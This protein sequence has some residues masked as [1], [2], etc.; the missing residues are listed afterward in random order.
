MANCDAL[1]SSDKLVERGKGRLR[2]LT[3][4]VIGTNLALSEP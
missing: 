4:L 1:L 3:D 2:D